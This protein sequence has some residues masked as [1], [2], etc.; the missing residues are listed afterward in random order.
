MSENSKSLMSPSTTMLA[1]ASTARIESTKSLTTWACWCRCTSR[2]ASRRLEA[3]EQ[4]IVAALGVEV[5]GDHE[6][7]LARGSVNSPTSGLRLSFHAVLVGSIRPGLNDSCGAGCCRAT[8][9]V[10]RRRRPARAVDE[11]EAAVGAEQEADADVAAG[12]RRRPRC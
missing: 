9:P 11:R 5:V 7:R 6:H 8:T 10:A 1:R 4:R 3:A 2:D 12:L